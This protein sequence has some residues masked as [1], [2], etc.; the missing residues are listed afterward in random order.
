[1]GRHRVYPSNRA[2]QRAYRLR[3]HH[4]RYEAFHEISAAPEDP[5]RAR[6]FSETVHREL[7]EFI[8]KLNKKEN[9][10]NV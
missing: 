6:E 1:M 3:K 7:Q 10:K 4:K 5:Q 9:T 2:K 8:D